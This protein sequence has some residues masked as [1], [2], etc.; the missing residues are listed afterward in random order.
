LWFS[1]EHFCENCLVSVFEKVRA[2][3]FVKQRAR[4]SQSNQENERLEGLG[5]L[6]GFDFHFMTI[7]ITSTL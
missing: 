3:Q 6:G 7:K 5:G 4:E 1:E 2:D